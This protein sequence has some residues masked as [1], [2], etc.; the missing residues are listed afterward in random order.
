MFMFHMMHLNRIVIAVIL[1]YVYI[2]IK[3]TEVFCLFFTEE[4]KRLF[5]G[6]AIV[7]HITLSCIFTQTY[8]TVNK[9]IITIA[10]YT[11]RIN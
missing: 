2:Y 6:F 8:R 11:C 10:N 5:C 7:L 3:R 4:Q 1:V 9:T